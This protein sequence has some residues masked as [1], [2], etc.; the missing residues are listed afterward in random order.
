MPGHSLEL[1]RVPFPTGIDRSLPKRAFDRS[2][3]AILSRSSSMLG[4]LSIGLSSLVAKLERWNKAGGDSDD[5][6]S[7]AA[8]APK[9]E[10]DQ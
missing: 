6:R 9:D 1:T 10:S 7:S 3:A 2:G 5:T 8:D 4:G